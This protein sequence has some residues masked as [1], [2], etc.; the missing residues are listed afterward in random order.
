MN[1]SIHIPKIFFGFLIASFLIWLLINL[2]KE[3]EVRVKYEVGFENLSQEKIFKETPI[4][5]IYL[6]VKANGFKLF[7]NHFSS[8]KVIFSID[9]LRRKGKSSSYF[10]LTNSQKGSV[11]NQLKSGIELIEILKDS[12]HFSLG[13]LETKKVPVTLESSIK[14]KLGF[15]IAETK[16][17]PDSVII[18]GAASEIEN[19]QSLKTQ[20]A[21]FKEVSEDIQTTLAVKY[22]ENVGNIKFNTTSVDVNIHVDK[23]TEGSFDVPVKLVNVPSNVDVNIYPK[24]VTVIYKV[25]LKNYSKI[26]EDSFEIVCDYKEAKEKG[27]TYL[28]PEFK[29]NSELVSSV[30][31]S[32]QKID[33]LIHK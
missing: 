12:I 24:K 6:S 31:I 13:T 9:K 28:I 19:I 7:S 22:P 14:F 32:P 30:R 18:S 8:K 27:L 2:S 3:Y 16:I 25:G 26:T 4:D 11:Q 20:I 17:E 29:N 10:F 33:F 23:F 15:G 21:D 5:R 1:K